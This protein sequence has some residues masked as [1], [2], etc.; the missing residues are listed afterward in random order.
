MSFAQKN[1]GFWNM[2]IPKTTSKYLGL[3]VE[4]KLPQNKLVERFWILT[5]KT[6]RRFSE[7]RVV[8]HEVLTDWVMHWRKLTSQKANILQCK[9]LHFH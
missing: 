9:I 6:P 5:P 4:Q 2:E 7:K 1:A 3:F 8:H